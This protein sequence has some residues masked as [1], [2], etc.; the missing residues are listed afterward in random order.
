MK[1]K[2]ITQKEIAKKLNITQGAVSGWLNGNIK[3]SLKNA[4]ALNKAFS[5]I[6]IEV[7]DDLPK[8]VRDNS[9]LFGRLKILREANNGNASV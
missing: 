2:K 4:K 7:C 9:Q 3:P 8:F 5:V 6:P 1:T